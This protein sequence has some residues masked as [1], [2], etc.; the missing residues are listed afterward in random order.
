[1]LCIEETNKSTTCDHTHLT[2][3]THSIDVSKP[4]SDVVKRLGV[5]D[6]IHQENAHSA[7]V[8]GCGD[9]VEPLLASRVPGGERGGHS[10]KSLCYKVCAYLVEMDT[11]KTA[12][13]PD[14]TPDDTSL[15]PFT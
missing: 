13:G 8:V 15:H 5:S 4:P 14:L 6:V 12:L 9:G 3:P 2:T 11:T 7:P 10:I 1:M